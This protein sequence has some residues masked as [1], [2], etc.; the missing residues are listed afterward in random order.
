[1]GKLKDA[2]RVGAEAVAADTQRAC[3]RGAAATAAGSPPRL[4]GGYENK[5]QK[6][7]VRNSLKKSAPTIFSLNIFQTISPMA[8]ES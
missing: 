7:T 3:A 6:P 4:I 1:M 8:R 2:F 5:T